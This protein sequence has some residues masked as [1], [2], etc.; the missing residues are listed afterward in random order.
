MTFQPS[1]TSLRIV[2][3]AWIFFS[4]DLKSLTFD[5]FD[6][7]QRDAVSCGIWRMTLM[8]SAL[9]HMFDATQEDASSRLTCLERFHV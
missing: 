3:S 1:I 2:H 9:V 6:G 8:L 7:T 4:S 5:M